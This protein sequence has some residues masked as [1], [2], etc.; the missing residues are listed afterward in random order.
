MRQLIILALIFGYFIGS[1]IIG[2]NQYQS[3]GGLSTN[4]L[5]TQ[6]VFLAI[7][8]F[9]TLKFQNSSTIIGDTLATLGGGI[10]MMII[11]QAILFYIL[12]D[13]L[14]AHMGTIKILL[15]IIAAIV[16]VRMVFKYLVRGT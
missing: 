2:V 6:W 9:C 16:I 4:Y 11:I 1:I 5:I 12:G 14:A 3:N 10:A 8:V 7:S 15:L 13:F